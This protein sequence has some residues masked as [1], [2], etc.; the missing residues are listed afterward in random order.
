MFVVSLLKQ[1]GRRNPVSS[2]M[3]QS[4]LTQEWFWVP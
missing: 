3:V 1:S 4:F 2:N